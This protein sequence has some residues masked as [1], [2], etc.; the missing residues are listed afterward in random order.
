M[1]ASD[2]TATTAASP[3]Q[4]PR[5]RMSGVLTATYAGLGPAATVFLLRDFALPLIAMRYLYFFR[6]RAT[7]I[8]AS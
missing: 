5:L 2:A 3:I 1:P 7:M 6:R 8:A 4:N